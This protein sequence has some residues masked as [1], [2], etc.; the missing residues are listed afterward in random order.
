MNQVQKGSVMKV[1]MLTRDYPPRIGGVATHV[2]GLVKALT[3]RGITV[4]VFAGGSDLRTLTMP[5]RKRLDKFD[6]VH[7]QSSPYGALVS[8]R[9]LVVTVHAPVRREWEHYTLGSKLKSVVA[10]PCEKL[11]FGKAHAILSV[12]NMTKQDL[13]R[14]YGIEE[15]VIEVIGNGVDLATF[16]VRRE[17]RRV[18]NRI[19]LVSR[20]EPRKNID[21]AIISLSKFRSDQYEA[22]IAGEGS[23]RAR[24]E[25][26]ARDLGVRVM[27]LGQVSLPELRR[28][29]AEADIFIST[30]RSEGFG[31]SVLE[32]MAAGCAVIASGIP[33]HRDM[34]KDGFNGLLYDDVSE[35]ESKMS[36][37]LST[38]DRVF[39]LGTRA[40]ETA[41]GYSW[42]KVA[43]RVLTAYNRCLDWN[44][45]A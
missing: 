33:T 8:G 2:A 37:L 32:S 40:Q 17:M 20:L 23:Q 12:S 3:K 15:R 34:I 45:S 19:L 13:V 11:T 4:E 7:V 9:P 42:E 29:Y 30:S 21:E 41:S 36:S 14:K 31:L 39:E 44:Q 38:P 22:K 24:L 28:L 1:A 25:R 10:Y 18:A 5:L 43:E 27:F 26:L 35:L 16:A 6:L